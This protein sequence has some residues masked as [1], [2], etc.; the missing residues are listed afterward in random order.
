MNLGCD[1]EIACSMSGLVSV[2]TCMNAR[3]GVHDLSLSTTPRKRSCKPDTHWEQCWKLAKFRLRA[4]SGCCVATQ[5]HSR[6][7]TA[8]STSSL[9]LKF[10]NTF[11]MTDRLSQKWFG[12]CGQV[13][14]LQQRF[15]PNFPKPSIG[16][17]QMSIT[18]QKAPEDT[19]ASTALPN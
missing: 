5:P 1:P 6:L 7:T 17:C 14:G 2:V 15:L 4:P 11:K 18:L 9:P 16:G 13:A 3:V 8:V 12:C 19:F 10:S